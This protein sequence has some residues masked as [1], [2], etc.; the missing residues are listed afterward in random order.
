VPEYMTI[1]IK[2]GTSAGCEIPARK[3]PIIE[4]PSIGAPQATV[5]IPHFPGNVDPLPIHCVTPRLSPSIT[6]VQTQAIQMSCAPLLLHA[7]GV[8][9]GD[10]SI[11]TVP[12]GEGYFREL[13]NHAV[14]TKPTVKIP[15]MTNDLVAKCRS[16]RHSELSN[17]PTYG[18]SPIGV[19]LSPEDRANAVNRWISLPN[20]IVADEK[21]ARKR[22]LIARMARE[23]GEASTGIK[24]DTAVQPELIE[25]FR[26]YELEGGKN[27]KSVN[28]AFVGKVIS[29]TA[30]VDASEKT[31]AGQEPNS[32]LESDET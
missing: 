5:N 32:T 17:P 13:F 19:H 8:S 26:Q 22:T 3:P 31:S 16:N 29:T 18:R 4:S 27:G 14:D 25:C 21:A 28:R 2:E 20:Q 24:R 6:M 30:R 10:T 12:T 11:S 15:S 9:R 23:A 7:D 1:P